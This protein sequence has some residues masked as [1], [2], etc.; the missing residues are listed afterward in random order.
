LVHK[1]AAKQQI[2]DCLSFYAFSPTMLNVK[3]I[4]N[5]QVGEVVV[6]N[7]RCNRKGQTGV[8]QCFTPKKVRVLFSDKKTQAFFESSLNKIQQGQEHYMLHEIPETRQKLTC[9]HQTV[10]V[11]K[12][13]LETIILGLCDT[14]TEL[15]LAIE[16]NNFELCKEVQSKIGNFIPSSSKKKNHGHH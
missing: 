13:D 16:Q 7:T 8:V 15:K 3:S 6:V 12:A 9:S 10:T 5:L 1:N 4:N 11:S 14:I 2:A